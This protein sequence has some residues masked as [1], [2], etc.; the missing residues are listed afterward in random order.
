MIPSPDA[1]FDPFVM[2]GM[3]A[4]RYRRVRIGT[5][6]TEPFRRHPATLAQAFVTIDHLTQRARHPRHRQRRARE[7]RAVRHAVH[8]ARG[9]AR[10]G[11]RDH[12]PALGE[13]RRAGRLRR[14]DLDA[15]ARALRD[16]ALQGQGAG[17]LGRRARAAHARPHR[18]LRRR[19]VPDAEDVSP[20]E[21]REGL[22]RIRAAAAEAG[23]DLSRLRAG[24]ADPARARPRPA[25]GRSSSSRR[26]QGRRRD[27]AAAA[28]RAVD[29]STG[30]RI[31][32]A[33]TSRASPT[34][35]PKR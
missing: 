20:A 25:I 27:V 15:Q 13:P 28:R 4:A 33:T 10:G 2:M 8:E 1:F 30:S 26:R 9:A 6:V 17:H 19:L 11:A 29:A 35:F 3:M 34:S 21:Y 31:R 7:H 23:R 24:D 5:G 14:L 12:P 22:D 16:A 32:S 18:P